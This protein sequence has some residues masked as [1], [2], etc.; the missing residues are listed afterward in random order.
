MKKLLKY[1]LLLIGLT[2]FMSACEDWTVPEATVC[3]N[4]SDRIKKS[5]EYYENLRAYKNTDH[6]IAFGWFGG[7]NGGHGLTSMIGALS[8]APDSMDILTIWSKT[9][10]NLDEARKKDMKYVQEVFG[11]KVTYTVFSHDMLNLFPGSNTFENTAENIPA[12]AKALADSIHKYG[13]DGIDFDYE[14]GP[15][16]LFYNKNNMT[17][18]LREVRKHI[19]KRE[20][21]GKIILVDGNLDYITEEGWTYVDYAVSQAYNTPSG[22]SLQT[23]YDKIK[24]YVSPERFIVT[25]DF[26]NHWKIGGINYT[27]DDKQVIPSLLGMAQWNPIEGRKGGIG[28]YHLE[29]EYGNN[30]DYKFMRKA[31]QM[32]NPAKAN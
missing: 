20:D 5:P 10:Y 22:T 31:I 13:Y 6:P 8:S 3:Q 18:L 32:M 15:T 9:F 29:Y 26:E 2:T 14:C 30:P 24:K 19:G 28:A 4:L 25:E 23:R 1:I 16:S 12:A 27:T 7:W 11:T 17:T 21:T